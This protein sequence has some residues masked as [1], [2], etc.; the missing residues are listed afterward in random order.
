MGESDKTRQRANR[1][2]ITWEV[3]YII[4]SRVVA[5]APTVKLLACEYDKTSLMRSQHWFR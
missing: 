4:V 2:Y 5:W 3:L 1:E